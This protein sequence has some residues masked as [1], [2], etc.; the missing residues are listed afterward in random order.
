MERLSL[1]SLNGVFHPGG[2]SGPN[3]NVWLVWGFFRGKK[4]FTIKGLHLFYQQRHEIMVP[5]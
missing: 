3:V 5:A 1:P 2:I 4:D